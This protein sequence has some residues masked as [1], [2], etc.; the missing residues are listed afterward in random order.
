MLDNN[1]KLWPSILD[2]IELSLTRLFFY[3]TYNFHASI[4]AYFPRI[5]EKVKFWGF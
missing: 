1:Q 4:S 2:K 5:E 3:Q